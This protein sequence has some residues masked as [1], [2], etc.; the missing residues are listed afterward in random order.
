M[1][2]NTKANLFRLALLPLTAAVLLATGCTS[3]MTSATQSNTG[4]VYVVGTDAPLA[5]VT[6]F[7]VT[8][9]TI[10]ATNTDNQTVTL[11]NSATSVDFA[12]YNGLQ[13]LLDMNDVTPGTYTSVTITL[14]SGSIYYLNTGS[15]APTIAN[16][17][18]T[19]A[20]NSNP[21][22][23]Q[24]P[25]PLV[26]AGTGSTPVGLRIDFDLAQSIGTTNGAINGT[27]TPTFDVRAVANADA[28]GYIDE[29]VAGV[30]S[31][32]QPAQS[33]VVQGPHGE[34]FT[35]DVSGS[36]E[37]DGDASLSM[38]AGCTGTCIVAGFRPDRP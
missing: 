15:G 3:S 24:L 14:G 4:P 33:F 36:T 25:K 21:V 23:V 18:A 32:N 20:A 17:P 1:S 19:Y 6:S 7:P 16:M 9:N 29:F 8:V 27:V 26:V 10:T 28:G 5:A 22:T 38:L 35:I 34:N 2:P 11:L 13:A 30:V 31:V 12:R 37:W